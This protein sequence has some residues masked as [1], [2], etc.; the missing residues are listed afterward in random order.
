M[1]TIQVFGTIALV[2]L[3]L[4]LALAI[5]I[6]L[7]GG[8]TTSTSTA[9][10]TAGSSTT[11]TA[12]TATS[13][14]TGGSSSAYAD[15]QQS[16]QLRVSVNATSLAP[17]KTLEVNASEYNTLNAANN[18]T[19]SGEWQI[20]AA[21]GSCPN[22]DVQPFGIALFQ[23][24]YAPQNVSQGTQLQ[25][26]PITACPMFERLVTGYL[27]QPQSDS[28]AVLPGSSV[29]P[30]VATIGVNATYAIPGQSHELSPGEYTLVAADE[31]GAMAFIYITVD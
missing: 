2:T 14:G 9:T 28:A 5:P 1:G 10:S 25:I 4:G 23:G 16:L 30:M 21:V 24:H 20:Q 7:H 15:S 18:V 12:S 29:T 27:F 8:N 11:S 3:A 19:K 31:W 22:T 13:S 6:A 17:G 26:F